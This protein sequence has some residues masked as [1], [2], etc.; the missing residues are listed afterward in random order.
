MTGIVTVSWE[1]QIETSP[2]PIFF[3]NWAL[4][5]VVQCSCQIESWVFPVKENSLFLW[6]AC[7][8]ISLL[9]VSELSC[10][11]SPACCSPE[12]A[13]FAPT[14]FP[15]PASL[16][17]VLSQFMNC[18]VP[19]PCCGPLLLASFTFLSGLASPGVGPALSRLEFCSA[20]LRL[21][22]QDLSW[23]FCTGSGK[24]DLF[25]PGAPSFPHL[26]LFLLN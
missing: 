19:A 13:F 18:G 8:S 9:T 15:L 17:S 21:V 26:C 2:G 16:G 12:H 6:T 10:H 20:A 14:R 24:T 4:D 7:F 23:H 5:W 1:H 25:Y 11:H 3:W 22:E